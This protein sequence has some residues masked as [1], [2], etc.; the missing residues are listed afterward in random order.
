ML[1]NEASNELKNSL[2]NNEQ[3]NELIPPNMHRRNAA[4]KAIRTMKNQILSGKASCDK[5]SLFMNGIDF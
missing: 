1:D 4:K 2:T 5:P 3:K